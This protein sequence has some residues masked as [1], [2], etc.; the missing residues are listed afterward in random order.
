M[1]VIPWNLPPVTDKN[2]IRRQLEFILK[3]DDPISVNFGI[4]ISCI[5]G[6]LKPNGNVTK[7]EFM[8]VFYG[9]PEKRCR[10]AA[11]NVI[12]FTIASKGGAR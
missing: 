8:K 7:E 6:R 1:S 10:R 5:L 12:P 4:H 2:Q 11:G 3:H 9:K